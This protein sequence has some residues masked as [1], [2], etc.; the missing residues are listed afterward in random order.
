MNYIFY[1][2]FDC[3][4]LLLSD[5]TQSYTY[6]VNMKKSESKNFDLKVPL[7]F[8][9]PPFYPTASA[10]NLGKIQNNWALLA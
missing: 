4:V 8:K 3:S 7:I 5:T 2:A 1:T 10:S 9:I 6:L